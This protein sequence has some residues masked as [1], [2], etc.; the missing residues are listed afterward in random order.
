MCKEH[1]CI[2][3]LIPDNTYG[4]KAFLKVG[5]AGVG[6]VL[7]AGISGGFGL[8]KAWAQPSQGDS[9]ASLVQEFRDA[10]RKHEVPMPLLMAIGYVNTRW[11]MPP[12]EI[13]AYEDGDT[14]GWGGY[15]IMALVKNP[16]SDTLGEAAELTGIS[17]E[18]LKSDRA[19][20]IM[21]GAALLAASQGENKP[22]DVGEWFRALGGEGRPSRGAEDVDSTAGI[23]G[24]ELYA[25]QVFETL[26]D[27]VSKRT[28]EGEEVS[29]SAQQ[30]SRDTDQKVSEQISAAP[31]EEE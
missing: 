31:G 24:G 23:G 14:H 9:R 3:S 30:L 2:G 1:D 28:Q 26:R 19:A 22:G 12:Q 29:L 16:S 11:E 18:E 20:N 10:S 17:E 8:S 21:G 6:G 15:G 4:R 5:A 7:F 25:A 13:S 27:G